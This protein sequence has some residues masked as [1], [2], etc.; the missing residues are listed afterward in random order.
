[1]INKKASSQ[2][3]ATNPIKKRKRF[4]NADL[5]TH[6]GY[7]LDICPTYRVEQNELHAPRGRVSMVLGLR[8]YQADGAG[9][10][11]ILS[12]CLVCRACHTVCP[13]GV[14]P[15]KLV[16]MTRAA[17]PTQKHLMSDALHQIT[18]HHRRTKIAGSVLRQYQ[19]RG[20]HGWL[21][22]V[23]RRNVWLKGM[24]PWL[25]ILPSSREDIPDPKQ[26][27]STDLLSYLP[28]SRSRGRVAL[29][30]G[31]IARLFLPSI[32]QSATA[33][34]LALGYDLVT[35]EGFGCCGAPHREQGVREHFLTQ[36]RKTID[37]FSDAG[38]PDWIICDSGVCAITARGY[39][40]AL[41]R[42][43]HYAEAAKR[44]S[45]R[46][47]D[48]GQFLALALKDLDLLWQDNGLGVL[49]YHDHCQGIH[50]LKIQGEP[51]DV[52]GQLQNQVVDLENS[53][54]CCGAGGDYMLRYPKRSGL[55]REDK[56]AAIKTS[57]A[58]TVV[59]VNP[60]C[61]MNIESGL[62]QKGISVKVR[63]LAEVVWKSLVGD[64]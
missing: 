59:A 32:G 5:C 33:T 39:G 7:C 14:R 49:S 36:A 17:T 21:K 41:S 45:E 18:D 29:L 53:G 52:L 35:P 20:F 6:C 46:V 62:R 16:I 27:V 63:H 28:K 2:G 37:A 58:D 34:I 1:M 19:K 64:R 43:D 54:H 10:A 26:P 23:L 4:A 31:C 44:F 40:K 11:E 8:D 12:S 3:S 42:D 24:L 55:I 15:G 22:G 13:V 48:M 50:G 25:D 51:R 47:L 38:E 30:G 56:L 60:G 57:G 61:L 9:V